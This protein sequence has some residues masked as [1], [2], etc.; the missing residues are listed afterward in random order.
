MMTSDS[1]TGARLNHRATKIM[2]AFPPIIS[3]I[4]TM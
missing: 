1:P 2:S 3:S 4:P